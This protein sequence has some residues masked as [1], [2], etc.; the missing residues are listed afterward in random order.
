MKPSEASGQARKMAR[1]MKKKDV[2]DFAKTKHKGLPKRVKKEMT[3][4]RRYNI[5]SEF[6]SRL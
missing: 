3:S 5:I 6:F 4:T 1:T 2:K